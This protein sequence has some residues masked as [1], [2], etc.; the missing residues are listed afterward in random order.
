MLRFLKVFTKNRIEISSNKKARFYLYK[1]Q[2]KDLSNK[3]LLFRALNPTIQGKRLTFKVDR[4]K[5]DM[6]GQFEPGDSYAFET[7]QLISTSF[8]FLTV[9]GFTVTPENSNYYSITCIF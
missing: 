9:K 2:G 3:R 6:L 4:E 1:T 8:K 7:D 5:L